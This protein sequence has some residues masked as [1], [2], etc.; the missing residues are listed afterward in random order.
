MKHEKIY[1]GDAGCRH[2]WCIREK[3]KKAIH[4]AF[5]TICGAERVSSDIEGLSETAINKE[6]REKKITLEKTEV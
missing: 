2:A 5:C 6:I 4:V 3:V 1:G